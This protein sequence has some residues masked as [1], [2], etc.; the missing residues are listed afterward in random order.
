MTHSVSIWQ[1]KKLP[2]LQALQIIDRI[3][4]NFEEALERGS[5]LTIVDKRNIRQAIYRMKKKE[6]IL[7][8]M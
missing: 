7:L 5:F 4:S 3:V 2:L 1:L 6:K 8:T